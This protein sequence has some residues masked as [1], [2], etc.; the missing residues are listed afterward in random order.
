MTVS[1]YEV[2]HELVVL[3]FLWLGA[4]NNSDYHAMYLVIYTWIPTD[5]SSDEDTVD[6]VAIMCI[7]MAT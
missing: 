3:S 1:R 7:E 2:L 6:M 4:H 5:I